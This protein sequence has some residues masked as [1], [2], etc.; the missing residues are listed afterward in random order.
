MLVVLRLE[1]W[2]RVAD[3]APSKKKDELRRQEWPT[4]GGKMVPAKDYKPRSDI[5]TPK[6]KSAN[7]Q[8]PTKERGSAEVKQSYADKVRAREKKAHYQDQEC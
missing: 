2:D 4:G 3:Q 6:P 7:V 5:G 1:Q 8:Q